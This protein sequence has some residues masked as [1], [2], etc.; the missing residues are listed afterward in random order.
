MVIKFYFGVGGF[1]MITYPILEKNVV[2]VEKGKG[3]IVQH[4]KA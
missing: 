3:T 4:F 1:N 2:E